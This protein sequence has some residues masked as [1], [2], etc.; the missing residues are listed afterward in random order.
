M[1]NETTGPVERAIGM[2]FRV[3]LAVIALYLSVALI[4]SIWP[5]L[6]LMAGIASIGGIIAVVVIRATRNR[7]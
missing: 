6:L 7:W 1:S 2:C 3:L 5:W 4:Q